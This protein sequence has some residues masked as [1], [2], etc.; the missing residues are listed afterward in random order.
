MK[1]LATALVMVF[2][3][4]TALMAQAAEE[5]MSYD[6]AT[7]VNAEQLLDLVDSNDNLVIIDS[8]KQ[9]D[10]DKGHIPDVVHLINTETNADSLAQAIASKDTPVCF[11]CNGPTCHRSGDAAQKAVAEGYSKVYWFRGGIAE[12]KEKGYPVEM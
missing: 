10:Y 9:A 4:F 3:A 7:T 11:Y 1:N 12:W 5:P 8:R 6:G 2:A